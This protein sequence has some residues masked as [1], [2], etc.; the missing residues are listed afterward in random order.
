MRQQGGS[1][2]IG[3]CA[4]PGMPCPSPPVPRPAVPL[5]D[6]VLSASKHPLPA[7]LGGRFAVH[8]ERAL[9][10]GGAFAKVLQVV[11]RATG[12]V[13]ALKVLDRRS[14]ADR[15]IEAQLDAE[16]EALKL[17]SHGCD[18]AR[19]IVQ[20]LEAVEERQMVY[21]R[22]EL[23][24]GGDLQALADARPD[25]RLPEADVRCWSRQLFMGLA[26]L[27]R[28]GILHRDVKPANLLLCSSG[29]SLRIADLGWCAHVRDV[30][31]GLAGT[32]EFMA[33]EVL[34]Q[35]LPQTEAVDCWSAGASLYQLLTGRPLLASYLG[36]GA[37]GMTIAEPQQA[38]RMKTEKL[39]LELQHRLPLERSARPGY[40]SEAC[41][42][43]LGRL[44]IVRPGF[45]ALPAAVLLH[46]WF[47]T[48]AAEHPRGRLQARHLPSPSPPPCSPRQ[49]LPPPRSP[50]LAARGILM[51]PAASPPPALTVAA[52]PQWTGICT[53]RPSPPLVTRSP[54]QNLAPPRSPQVASRCLCAEAGPPA[55]PQPP[56]WLGPMAPAPIAPRA[57]PPQA[58]RSPRQ[59]LAA[60]SQNPQFVSATARDARD[61]RDMQPVVVMCASA[62][63]G[64]SSDRCLDGRSSPPVPQRMQ[65]AAAPALQ[66]QSSPLLGHREVWTGAKTP[67]PP[68][69]PNSDNAPRRAGA[70]QAA[71]S[72][73]RH[74]N[75]SG[76]A[77]PPVPLRSP[78]IVAP[79]EF[80]KPLQ[81]S[82]G[83]E[84]SV[85]YRRPAISA[86]AAAAAAA[87]AAAVDAQVVVEPAQEQQPAHQL[88]SAADEAAGAPA[89]AQARVLRPLAAPPNPSPSPPQWLAASKRPAAVGAQSLTAWD[90]ENRR[91]AP[92]GQHEALRAPRGKA[93]L[94][95]DRLN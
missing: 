73:W 78:R 80:P 7:A 5:R 65:S 86:A 56:T 59:V 10:G 52:S 89:T 19:H 79:G 88:C 87:I 29:L 74:G 82:K 13:F 44:L 11:E 54:R 71:P 70:V 27:H 43:A 91:A 77:T 16:I 3:G 94:L 49:V 8:R 2:L 83:L 76:S 51:E 67:C 1:R 95:G 62:V 30:P 4:T 9:L 81:V 38:T 92:S 84:A 32:M 22:M 6:E 63:S 68:A 58:L 60:P 17:C 50:Q 90:Q 53:P 55:P 23:C 66:P 42:D 39:L 69:P 40:L 33:P 37:T 12:Q 14:Y 36:P 31:C 41:W 85:C 34:A 24:M 25:H 26:E 47:E 45:R 48:P 57:S 15:G 61:T 35:R 46:A 21:L 72:V 64:R 18:G 28:V 75:G 20:L 93:D